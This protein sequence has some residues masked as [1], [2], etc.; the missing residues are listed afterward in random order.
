MAGMTGSALELDP[1]QW[2]SRGVY[3]LLTSLV[4]P[5]PIAWVSTLSADGVRNLAPH[6]YFNLVAH[7]PPHLIFSSSGVKD[8]LRNIRETEEFVVNI[9]T[10][11]LVE[12]MNF[13]STDFPAIEDEFEW[14]GLDAAPSQT[15]GPPRVAAAKAHLECRLAEI[16]TAGNGY[17]I[18]GRIK[19]IHVDGG[20]LS[21]GRVDAEALAPVCRLAGSGYAS[22]G[23]VFE[24]AR[25]KWEEVE[26]TQGQAA[27]P[28]LG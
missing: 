3:G 8:T 1:D 16:V 10:M 22:L 11:D 19:H 21:N 27:M 26:G 2:Q 12:K 9:V 5:R 25:P 14:A 7:D 28:R 6:S 15:V 24:L 20:V 23:P 4:I 18:V 17:I 13:T